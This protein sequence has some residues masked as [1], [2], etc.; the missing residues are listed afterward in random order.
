MAMAKKPGVQGELWDPGKEGR[1]VTAHRQARAKASNNAANNRLRDADAVLRHTQFHIISPQRSGKTAAEHADNHHAVDARQRRAL[2]VNYFE[3][4][5]LFGV[6][7]GQ[8]Q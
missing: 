8:L 1:K 6:H 3:V 5:P 2:E 7:S 4:A